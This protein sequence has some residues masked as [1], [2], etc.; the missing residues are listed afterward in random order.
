MSS[1]IDPARVT[2][3]HHRSEKQTMQAKQ[4]GELNLLSQSGVTK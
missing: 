3:L 4:Q 1:S 2:R